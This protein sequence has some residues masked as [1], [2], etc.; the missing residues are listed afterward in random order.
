MQ[1]LFQKIPRAGVILRLGM[2]SRR[3]QT[4]TEPFSTGSSQDKCC[5]KK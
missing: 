3:C 4:A 1:Y 2:I 5:I